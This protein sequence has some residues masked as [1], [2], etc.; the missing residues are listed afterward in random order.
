M[1]A[2]L[3]GIAGRLVGN[4]LNQPSAIS[5]EAAIAAVKVFS[6]LTINMLTLTDG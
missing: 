6:M 3:A 5:H 1:H 2:L 4:L